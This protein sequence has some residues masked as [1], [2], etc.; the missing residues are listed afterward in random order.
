MVA[1]CRGEFRR[2]AVEACADSLQ[3]WVNDIAEAFTGVR[4]EDIDAGP[5]TSGMAPRPSA[6]ALAQQRLN[7]ELVKKWVVVP[8]E[9]KAGGGKRRCPICK[10]EFVDEFVQDEEEW[11]WR[12]CVK[13]KNSVSRRPEVLNHRLMVNVCLS[14][15][16]LH[17]ERM[18]WRPLRQIEKQLQLV[19]PIRKLLFFAEPVRAGQQAVK[20]LLYLLVS[21]RRSHKAR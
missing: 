14:T 10:E 1:A 21:S 7:E 5:S 13:V 8:A 9:E 4:D 11:V 16:T 15:T 3:A 12:N 19:P 20:A 6:S 18:H 17:V 2:N